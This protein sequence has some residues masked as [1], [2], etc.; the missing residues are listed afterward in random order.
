MA[1]LDKYMMAYALKVA[2]EAFG[3]GLAERQDV[4]GALADVAMEAYAA[5]SAVTR[6]LQSAEGGALDPA[7][8]GCVALYVLEGHERAHV[9][10]KHAIRAAVP[11]ASACRDHLAT[12]RK[13]LVEEPV[14]V[15]A[16]REAVLERMLAAGRYPLAWS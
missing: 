2:V 5:D 3:P 11:D 13:L 16:L 9:R 4:L 7:A 10:A 15:T 6:A 14:D 8:E 1:E 12:L